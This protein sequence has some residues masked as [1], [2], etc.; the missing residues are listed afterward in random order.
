[1]LSD[2]IHKISVNVYLATA[3]ESTAHCWN[4]EDFKSD[5]TV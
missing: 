3:P 5:L 2:I 1:M 4:M